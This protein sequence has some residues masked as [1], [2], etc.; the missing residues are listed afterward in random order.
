MAQTTKDQTNS[1]KDS[2][3]QIEGPYRIH[4][5]ML[6]LTL[7]LIS[8]GLIML[9]SASMSAGYQL[10]KNPLHYI[11]SQG[12]STII[13]S[14]IAALI[15]L[16]PVKKF[17]RIILVI[18]AYFMTLGLVVYTTFFGVLQGNARRWIDIGSQRLEPSELAKIALIFCIAGYRSHIIRLRKAGKL[19]S[20]NPKRQAYLNCAFDIVIPCSA[21]MLCL[22]FVL[23]Q[24]HM[25]FIVI[26]S[27]ITFLCFLVSGIP[28]RTWIDGGLVMI[29]II[30]IGVSGLMMFSNTSQKDKFTSNFAHVTVRLNIF[31]TLNADDAATSGTAASETT[32]AADENEVYQSKQSMI[33]IGSGGISGVGFGSS[34]Q[35]YQYL[36][37]AHNDY[38]FAIACE[39]L[40]FVGGVSIIV[41]FWAYLCGGLSIAWR[42]RNDFARILVVGY[43]SLIAIQAFLNI[44][45]AVGV[46]PPTGITLPFFSYGGTANLVFMIA[47]GFVLAGSRTG[48][49]RKKVTYIE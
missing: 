12:M 29:L 47:A 49:R 4:L 23:I 30:L 20:D 27:L 25:S 28:L 16:I 42:T 18:L 15:I 1:N 32:A 13:G 9:F 41:L 2:V 19:R 14:V 43:T 39:E 46:V 7:I 38:V 31:Q 45:V 26:M 10:D 44:G 24:P 21:I 37:E 33:A 3:F 40:G 36:P 22:L 11:F 5:P 35:K 17:D 6:L 48:V 34:R 8:F